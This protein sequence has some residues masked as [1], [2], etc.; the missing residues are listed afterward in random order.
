MAAD[1]CDRGPIFAMGRLMRAFGRWRRRRAMRRR[2]SLDGL[3]GLSDRSLADIGLRRADLQAAT[4]GVIPLGRRA[5]DIAAERSTCRDPGRFRRYQPCR[6]VC[7][8][9]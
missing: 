4:M 7:A 5:T 3:V 6:V 9:V 8:K 1:H 2:A